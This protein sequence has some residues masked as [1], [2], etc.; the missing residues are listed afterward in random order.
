MRM[1]RGPFP[2]DLDLDLDLDLPGPHARR[3]RGGWLAGA[4]GRVGSRRGSRELPSGQPGP[5]SH[6]DAQAAES[7]QHP[8]PDLMTPARPAPPCGTGAREGRA[9]DGVASPGPMLVPVFRLAMLLLPGGVLP[10]WHVH[11]PA[12]ARFPVPR[13]PVLPPRI[14]LHARVPLPP[15]GARIRPRGV[16]RGAPLRSGGVR[17]RAGVL[18]GRPGRGVRLAS[19]CAHRRLPPQPA[20]RAVARG[21]PRPPATWATQPLD[22]QSASAARVTLAGL[23]RGRTALFTDLPWKYVVLTTTGPG[24]GR[25][26]PAG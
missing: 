9:R 25:Q 3:R 1:G 16:R 18:G 21:I 19:I 4:R 26:R 10:G 15:R 20:G 12:V 7:D 11:R 23:Q 5:D 8:V 24:Y 6:D 22:A 17:I 14:P 13:R 2:A